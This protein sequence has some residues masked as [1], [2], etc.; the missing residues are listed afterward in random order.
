MGRESGAP[1]SKGVMS[2]VEG[3]TVDDDARSKKQLSLKQT[4]TVLE[5]SSAD[6]E[7]TA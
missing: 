3:E 4:G 2:I 1:V 5:N 7:E 6:S